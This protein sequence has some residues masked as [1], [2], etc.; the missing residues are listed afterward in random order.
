MGWDVGWVKD[1]EGNEVVV[2]ASSGMIIVEIGDKQVLRLDPEQADEFWQYIDMAIGEY[3][4]KDD[5]LA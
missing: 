5:R 2:V 1:H 4:S 3:L